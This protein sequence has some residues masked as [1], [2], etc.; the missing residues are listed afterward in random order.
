MTVKQYDALYALLNSVSKK[1]DVI[2]TSLV[3]IETGFNNLPIG[4]NVT[5][6]L[7]KILADIQNQISALKD[8]AKA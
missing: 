1:Q 3:K 6:T 2:I 5:G 7:S 8:E 4:S